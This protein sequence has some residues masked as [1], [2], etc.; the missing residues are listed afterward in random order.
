[1]KGMNKDGSRKEPLLDLK[2]SFRLLFKNYDPF[3]K[4][5]LFAIILTLL[6]FFI[7]IGIGFVYRSIFGTIIQDTPIRYIGGSFIAIFSGFIWIFL[8]TT[9]GLAVDVI[10]SGDEFTEFSN[11]FKYLKKF[12]WKYALIALIVFGFPNIVQLII[13]HPRVHGAIQDM[14]WEKVLIYEAVGLILSYVFYSLF[15]LVFP[16]VTT[17]GS[18]KNAFIE[19]FRILKSDGKRVF[20]TWALFFLVFQ[21]P[22][23]VFGTLTLIFQIAPFGI[24]WIIF[25]LLNLFI[26]MPLQ[27]LMAAGMYF[28]TNFERFKPLD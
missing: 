15:M 11:A 26:G 27:Y 1:M 5:Q 28:N 2:Q 21:V 16:S 3:L 14:P 20:G 22:I 25:M 19:N 12:W 7:I 17:T 6:I 8:T 13:N 9:N 23:Y 10:N 18:I 4:V 24:F